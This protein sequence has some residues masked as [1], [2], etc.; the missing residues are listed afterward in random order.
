VRNDI[1][2]FIGTR[3]SQTILLQL[4]VC[5]LQWFTTNGNHWTFSR[6]REAMHCVNDMKYIENGQDSNWFPLEAWTH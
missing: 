1:I 3:N 4:C 6:S 5:S 2:K